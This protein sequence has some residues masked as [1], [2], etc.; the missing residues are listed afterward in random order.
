MAQSR[1]DNS[2]DIGETG[3][4]Q[5]YA[6]PP[7]RIAPHQRQYLGLEAWD[8]NTFF[9]RSGDRFRAEIKLDP[10]RPRTRSLGRRTRW[11]RSLDHLNES[12]PGSPIPPVITGIVVGIVVARIAVAGSTVLMPCCTW[13]SLTRSGGSTPRSRHCRARG[14]HV[15]FE[16]SK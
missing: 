12:I 9:A 3:Y 4:V 15:S 5:R 2:R 16:V 6:I 1:E 11:E 13:C 10:L 7:A 8:P 14:F